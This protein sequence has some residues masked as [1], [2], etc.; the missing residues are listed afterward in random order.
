MAAGSLEMMMMMEM[1]SQQ[2]HRKT[3]VA[4]SY[5]QQKA[6]QALQQKRHVSTREQRHVRQQHRLPRR[7]HY[8]PQV[9]TMRLNS[10]GTSPPDPRHSTHAGCCA[11]EEGTKHPQQ[12]VRLQN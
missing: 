2:Q 7:Q 1:T 9:Q 12:P 6:L 8:R 10:K 11:H 4:S 3:A 5:P